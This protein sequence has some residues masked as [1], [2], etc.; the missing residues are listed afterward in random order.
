MRALVTLACTCAAVAACNAITGLGDDYVLVGVDGGAEDAVTG[1]G[2]AGAD[3]GPGGDAD[4]SGDAASDGAQPVFSCDDGPGG[5]VLFCSTFDPAPQFDGEEQQGGT[6]TISA[7]GGKDGGAALHAHA[8][9]GSVSRKANKWIRVAGLDAALYQHY[10]VAFDFRIANRTLSYA[11]I[12]VLAFPQPVSGLPYYGAAV[13][14]DAPYARL[15]VVDNGAAGMT[16]GG[17]AVEDKPAGTWHHAFM[18]FDKNGGTY[19][20]S[21]SIDGQQVDTHQGF[22]VL[23]AQGAELRI[24]ILFGDTSAGVIDVFVDD[25]VVRGRK[26]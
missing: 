21:L 12:G 25:V 22:D 14:D 7:T 19:D 10:E 8:N 13:H 15:D 23:S 20:L 5:Q 3:G 2:S 4:V 16:P 1:D 18:T 6:V 24:G 17:A 9:E 11:A 26:N